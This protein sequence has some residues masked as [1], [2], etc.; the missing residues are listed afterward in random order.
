MT[1]Q[2]NTGRSQ[3]AR[4]IAAGQP[5]EMA[6]IVRKFRVSEEMIRKAIAAV[7]NSR[8]QVENYIR[9]QQMKPA[10]SVG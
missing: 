6:Y 10:R 1:Q 3:D 9:R 7:G 4:L 2:T 5:W 8:L